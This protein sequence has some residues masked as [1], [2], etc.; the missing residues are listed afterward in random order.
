MKKTKVTDLACPIVAIG[1]SA[2]GLEALRAF[3]QNLSSQTGASYL[4]IQH[5]DPAHESLTA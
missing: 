1:A 4:V 2:G 5:L 3:F